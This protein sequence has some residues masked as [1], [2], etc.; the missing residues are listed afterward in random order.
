M[1]FALAVV[2]IVTSSTRIELTRDVLS[3]GT[4]RIPLTVISRAE[5]IAKVDA[6][7]ER[8]SNLDARA[9][10]RFAMTVPTLCKVYLADAN[11]VTPYWLFSSRNPEQLTA[12]LT[13]LIGGTKRS[14]PKKK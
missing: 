13:D 7:A 10:I 8:G 14:N 6:F 5:A 9:Y 1:A 4:A 3:V 11:D 2:V 12:L